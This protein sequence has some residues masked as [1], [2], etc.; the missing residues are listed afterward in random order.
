M[1]SVIDRPNIGYDDDAHAYTID[2]LPVPGVSSIA[3]IGGDS[4]GPAGWWG[5]KLGVLGAEQTLLR[6]PL[7][8]GEGLLD[9]VKQT[10]WRPDRKRDAAGKRGNSVH[11]ALE[12]LAQDGTV[13]DP[14]DYPVE[15]RGHVRSLVRWFL[16]YRPSFVATEVMV[17][18]RRH[19]YAGRYD[20]RALIDCER[21]GVDGSD[22]LDGC[23]LC[24]I[25]LKTSKGTYPE[26]HF[27]QLEGYEL[28]SVEMGFAPTDGG[29]WLLRTREDGEFIAHDDVPPHKWPESC[30][31][32]SW[33][34]PD[35]FLGYLAAYKARERVL[36]EDPHEAWVN[37]CQATLADLLTEGP[38][39]SR[40]LAK[41]PGLRAL[42]LDSGRAVGMMLG[43]MRKLGH[44][45]Q[46][47]NKSWVTASAA[48]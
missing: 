7:A 3:K 10:D 14:S 17:G 19:M 33:A 40:D 25:D 1:T 20:I 38:W 23:A 9:A 37:D 46:L 43:R 41:L 6:D 45:R 39:L 21:L 31:V 28:A 42:G 11:D 36:A 24:L 29:R 13:P 44:V 47:D 15:E 35:D 48:T 16:R 34:T 5:W 12:K 30:F 4:W 26:T 22:T 8:N 2:G 18:S 27:V 32:K